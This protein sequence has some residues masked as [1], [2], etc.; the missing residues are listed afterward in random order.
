[1]AVKEKKKFI[2]QEAAELALVFKEFD[3]DKSGKLSR[4]ELESL[5]KRFGWASMAWE[6]IDA[7]QD[8]DLSFLEVLK[9][10]YPNTPTSRLQSSAAELF[11]AMY[12]DANGKLLKQQSSRQLSTEQLAEVQAIFELH[13]KDGSGSIDCKE[14][15]EA[16]VFSGGYDEAE[17]RA[18]FKEFDVNCDGQLQLAEFITLMA[19]AYR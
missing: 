11:P 1:M 10:L 17:V 8:G 5:F 16:M 14:L 19:T 15:I 2:M 9:F 3:I 13:D 7:D 6:T 18:M 4:K 12:A